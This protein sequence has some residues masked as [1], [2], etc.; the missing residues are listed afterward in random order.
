MTVLIGI[1]CKDGIVIASDSQESDDE[2]VKRLGVRKIYD[3]EVFGFTDVAIAMAGAGTFAYV[4]RAIELITDKGY[5]PFFTR[6]RQV[7]DIVEDAVGEIAKRHGKGEDGRGLDFEL[8]L[9]VWCKN[10]PKGDPEDLDDPPCPIGLYCISPPTAGEKLGLAEKVDDYAAM[11][12]GGLFARYLL[13]RLHDDGPPTTDL[14][15]DEM[16]YEAI[17]VI[18]E[19]N[20]IDLYCGGDIHAVRIPSVGTKVINVGKESIKKI[21][22][23]LDKQDRLVR[24]NQREV[25]SAVKTILGDGGA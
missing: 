13:N 10:A 15:M 20:K 9:G 4:S 14:T 2:D 17:Y 21:I 22:L 19:V 5:G 23:A 18:I 24:Q 12:S 3:T 11:G 1:L 8:L 7:A 25:I 6:P 16:L